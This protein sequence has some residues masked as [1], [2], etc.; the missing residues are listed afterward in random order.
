M[1]AIPCPW[2][3][4]E[5]AL[6]HVDQPRLD[7]A[8]YRALGVAVVRQAV[9][10]PV[11][12][13]WMR[14]WREFQQ[15]S[16]AAGR[17][18]DPYNPVVLHEP[19][20]ETLQ[21]IHRHPVLL[22]LMEQL[23]PDLALYV[24]R[25][26]IKDADSRQPVFLHQD[27]CYDLGMPEKTSIFLPLGP[28]N[29]GNGGLMFYP[30]THLLGYLGDAGE[31]NPAILDPEW[32]VVSPSVEPGDVVLM[33]ECTWHASRPHTEGPDRI[34][35]QMTFQPADDPSG[36]ELLRGR[37]PGMPLGQVD[38]DALFLR[39]RSSRLRELQAAAQEGAASGT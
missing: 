7:I 17:K 12:D 10:R 35:V 28:M 5:D 33:H 9:P 19:V 20:S 6:P 16:L 29:P 15:A 38:R 39:S 14:A 21:S 25:F 34:V 2:H 32:P 1:N 4:L 23:Y 26:V 30:G 11:V 27:Y 36:I 24:Q 31:L 13:E 8:R 3:V 22:D 37:S 18:V